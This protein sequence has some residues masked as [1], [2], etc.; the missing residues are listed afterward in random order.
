MQQGID[1]RKNSVPIPN[2]SFE[3]DCAVIGDKDD[4]KDKEK[5]NQAKTTTRKIDINKI[6]KRG[7]ID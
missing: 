2:E 4:T 6:E 7:K 3:K 1:I 5:S